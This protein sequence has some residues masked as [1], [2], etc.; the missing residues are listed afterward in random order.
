M[1]SLAKVNNLLITDDDRKKG[2]LNRMTL[3]D[4]QDMS[5][6]LKIAVTPSFF[7]T[8]N[9]DRY[10]EVMKGA[11]SLPSLLAYLQENKAEIYDDYIAH[12]EEMKIDWG[13]V[14][15]K[16]GSA[17]NTDIV[18][19]MEKADTEDTKK[20]DDRHGQIGEQLEELVEVYF[21]KKSRKR[22]LKRNWDV[23]GR[24]ID[25][26]VAR[27]KRASMVVCRFRKTPMSKEYHDSC[28]ALFKKL[29]KRKLEDGSKIDTLIYVAPY[30]GVTRG[31]ENDARTSKGTIEILGEDFRQK[32]IDLQKELR[33]EDGS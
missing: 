28:Y 8:L 1:K 31:V 10:R 25:L 12:E 29:T 14:K 2:L 22:I 27:G 4:L 20:K 32:L 24:E 7:G 13:A 9:E 33:T 21:R 30:G 11:V 23:E 5:T 15:G 16:L 6:K 19:L 18:V 26:V 17:L 3:Q